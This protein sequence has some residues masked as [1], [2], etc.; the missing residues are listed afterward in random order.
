MTAPGISQPWTSQASAGWSHQLTSSTVIDVD[1]VH[2]KGKDLGVRWDLNTRVN[3]GS[4]RY[5]DLGLN[6]AN[7]RMNMSVGESKFDGVNFGIRRRMD[8]GISFNAWYSLSKAEGLG[9]LGVDELTTNLVQDS[10]NPYG[11]VQWGPRGRTDARHKVTLSAVV[12]A[13]RGAS[14]LRRSSAIGRR[15][16]STSGRATT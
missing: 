3:G 8:R 6:P 7:P 10:T 1:Y 14:M 2:I 5:A 9:G 15:C 16:R 11:D 13:A 12:P 4:R